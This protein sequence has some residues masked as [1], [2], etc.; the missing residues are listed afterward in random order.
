MEPPRA[1]GNGVLVNVA[2][3]AAYFPVPNVAVYGAAKAFVLSFTEALWHESRS[4]RR[5][6]PDAAGSRR[7]GA[8]GTRPAHPCPERGLRSAQ[9]LSWSWDP[10]PLSDPRRAAGRRVAG[11]V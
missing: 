2:S 5:Q 9:H 8:A 6:A 4:G 3:M 7:D 10:A 1:S 11:C